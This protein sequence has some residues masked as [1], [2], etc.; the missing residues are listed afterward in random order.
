MLQSA[1]EHYRAEQRITAAGLVAARRRRFDTLDALVR[2]VVG[3]QV[4]ASREAA[5]AFPAMLDEQGLDSTAEGVVA[6]TSL[7]GTAS[8]GRDLRGLMDYTRADEVTPSAF[9]LIVTTQLQDVARQTASIA[10]GV[11]PHIEGYVRILNP[12]S[13]SRCAVL[14]GKFFR[15]NQ[16]FDRHPKCDCRHIPASE[17]TAGDLRSDPRAYFDS[18]PTADE[19]AK[20]YPDLT[21]QMRRDAGIFSQEDIFTK[22]GADVIR[23]GADIGQVVNARA[24]M[25][26]S[27]PIL[28][29]KGERNTARGRIAKVDVFGQ[30]MFTTTEGMTKRG[31]AYKARGRQYV[32]LM[33]ESILEIADSEAEVLRL[34][35]VH[36]YIT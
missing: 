28:R 35:K 25:S 27:Q 15:R 13:C 9:D 24:G 32:R 8:D 16:G 17:D 11:R 19:L 18:L 33:P 5:R 23:K 6:T 20:Q 30:Q 21:V 10:L 4:L 2:T 12:P 34:L 22:A 1:V 3:F 36:G 31:I 7:A 14:A 29:G 26:T